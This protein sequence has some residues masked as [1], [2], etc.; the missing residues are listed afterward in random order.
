MEKIK[1]NSRWGDNYLE[2]L[3]DNKYKLHSELD[4]IRLGFKEDLKVI[5]FVDPPGGPFLSVGS[6]LPE[7]NDS[8]IKTIDD[9]EDGIIITVE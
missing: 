5:T 2:P 6:S 9:N 8:L 4:H 7:V 1:L 3:G